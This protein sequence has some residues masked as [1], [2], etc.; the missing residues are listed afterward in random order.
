MSQ[1][2]QSIVEAFSMQP[3]IFRVEKELG[4][5]SKPELTLRNIEREEVITHYDCGDAISQTCYI[6][7]NHEGAK[8]F[9]YLAKTVNVHYETS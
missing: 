9:Q 4:K 5:Y 3:A 6:G 7:Y 2:I 8:M 1:K